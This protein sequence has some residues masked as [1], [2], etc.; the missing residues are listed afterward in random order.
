MRP[1][2]KSKSSEFTY[3]KKEDSNTDTLA[4]DFV[5]NALQK[6]DTLYNLNMPRIHETFIE[7]KYK[8]TGDTRSIPIV[9]DHKED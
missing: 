4:Y 8:V 5:I 3:H 9:V 6:L 2:K 1:N 7:G